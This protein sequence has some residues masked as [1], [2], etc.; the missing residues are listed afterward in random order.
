[1]SEAGPVLELSDVRK[2]FVSRNPWNPLST[3]IVRAVDGVS[4]HVMRGETLALVGESGCGKSTVARIVVHLHRIDSGRISLLGKEVGSLTQSQFRPMRRHVQMVFQNPLTSFDP[5]YTIGSSVN[6]VLRLSKVGKGSRDEVDRLLTEVGL[7]PRFRSLR[8]Q[9]VSGGELQRA[10]IARSLAVHPELVVLDEPTSALDMSIQG[11]V[12]S[13]L[14]DLQGRHGLSY[15][16][17]THDLRVVEMIAHRVVVMY[18]GQ[19]VESAPTRVLFARPTHPYTQGLLYSRNLSGRTE[20]GDR[21]IRI[22]G[23]LRYPEPGYE[24]CRLVGRCPLAAPECRQP[25]ALIS[26]TPDHAIRCWKG[27]AGMTAPSRNAPT[28][29]TQS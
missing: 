2:T 11:Q 14:T 29:Q 26:I 3:R 18:L 24:G 16:L 23:A 17:A 21:T 28:D 15:L 5:A 27:V 7:S 4:L 19:I 22:R 9:A 10:A 1:M 12:L 13:L 8:P 25:Q 20:Q 6:E